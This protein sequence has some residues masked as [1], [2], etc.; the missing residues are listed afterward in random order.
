MAMDAISKTRPLLV[1]GRWA[2]SCSRRTLV[3]PALLSMLVPAA[4]ADDSR[5]VE[6][7][8]SIEQP[9]GESAHRW[10]R[11]AYRRRRPHVRHAAFVT[12]VYDSTNS[13]LGHR[14]WQDTNERKFRESIFTDAS[15]ADRMASKAIRVSA[16]PEIFKA[17]VKA[18]SDMFDG[19]IALTGVKVGDI[20]SVVEA[21]TGPS[22][23]YHR[24][25]TEDS[26]REGLF[27]TRFL[28]RM[29][30]QAA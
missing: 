9:H 27:P 28:E 24:C 29:P 26:Q 21:K 22:E 25:R 23:Y 16:D 1:R 8:R 30:L 3:D 15:H 20:V 6:E 14:Y 12:H 5:T 18:V 10:W 4:A 17:R 13:V 2:E 11:G 19:P 7:S